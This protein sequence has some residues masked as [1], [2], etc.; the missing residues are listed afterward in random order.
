MIKKIAIFIHLLLVGLQAGLH[1]GS[2]LYY[3]PGIDALSSQVLQ[4]QVQKSINFAFA[5]TIA[6][7]FTITTLSSLPVLYIVRKQKK[8]F[9]LFLI[10]C[11]CLIV[12][13]ISTI[14][15]NVPIN[16]FIMHSSVEA[17]LPLW[18][19]MRNRWNLFNILRTI[20]L[21]TALCIELGTLMFGI[22]LEEMEKRLKV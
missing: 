7:F 4:I 11:L 1:V 14:V 18:A 19:I 20:L 13:T 21:V 8:V 22:R 17:I 2:V 9:R 5:P 10:A 6:F 3:N 16:N 15:V 12:A